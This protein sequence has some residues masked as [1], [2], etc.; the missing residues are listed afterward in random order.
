MGGFFG[1]ACKEDSV[2][3]LFYG[4]DYHSHFGTMRGG[5]A[6]ANG[7]GIDRFIHDISSS[8]FR[9]KFEDDLGR[10]KGP[11]GIGV[12]SDFEDQPLIIGSHLGTYAI[13]T[14]G[15]VQNLEE[16][17]REAFGKGTHFSE[18]SVQGLNPTEVTAMLIN[19]ETSFAEGIA[20]AQ[21]RIEGSSSILL[22]TEEGIYAARDRLGR[23]PV[24]VGE[25]DGSW[26][27]TMETCALPNLGF[28]VKHYLGPGEIVLLTEEGMEQKRPPGERMQI[29]AFLWVY[30]GYPASSYEGEGYVILRHPET[31][32]VVSGL[33]TVLATLKVDLG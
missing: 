16:L 26:A 15:V 19:G 32:E 24:V 9:S 33:R 13:S 14:V 31:R 12:I 10:M 22:L 8:P 3:D 1:V 30:Y 27:V 28:E 6:V 23:T 29:C 4:T 11:R 17:A 7:G 2:L 5:M 21:D 20:H 18:M 25:K